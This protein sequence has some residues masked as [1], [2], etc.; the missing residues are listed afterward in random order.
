MK[1][2]GKEYVTVAERISEFRT[3]PIYENWSIQTEI[4]EHV[5]GFI[6]MKATIRNAE[7]RIISDGIAYET[8]EAQGSNLINLTSYIE[9]CQSS[10]WGR[11][12]ACLNIGVNGSIASADE[13]ENAVSR[14]TNSGGRSTN[15]TVQKTQSEQPEKTQKEFEVKYWDG[16]SPIEQFD[17]FTVDSAS[18]IETYK[19]M[20][21]KAD[22]SLFGLNINENCDPSVKFYS[23]EG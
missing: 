9:N 10:S 12:L 4:L 23:F 6:M 18:G 11:A 15:G 1:I 20:K 16:N 2:K 8:N 17:H 5:D 21:K 3:N 14:Q 22:N 19:T 7:D 13:V